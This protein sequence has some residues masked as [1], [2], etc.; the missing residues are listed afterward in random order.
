MLVNEIGVEDG[1]TVVELD[2]HRQP[3]VFDPKA[4]VTMTM[5]LQA[6]LSVDLVARSEA[7]PRV[8]REISSIAGNAASRGG[9][10]A[11]REVA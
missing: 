6:A 4:R 9:A 8:T 5:L 10:N 11:A 1:A 2:R 7:A 3:D